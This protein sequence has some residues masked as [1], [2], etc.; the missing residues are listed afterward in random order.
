MHGIFFNVNIIGR[1]HFVIFSNLNPTC[2][3]DLFIYIFKY[4]TWYVSQWRNDYIRVGIPVYLLCSRNDVYILLDVLGPLNLVLKRSL[5]RE[6]F[7]NDECDPYVIFWK[8]KVLF[9]LVK[10]E[11]V[12]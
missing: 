11:F 12:L 5:Y 8:F 4:L 7:L 1:A 10:L 2:V 6:Y 9:N 3:D